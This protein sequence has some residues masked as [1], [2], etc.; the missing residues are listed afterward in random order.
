MIPISTREFPITILEISTELLAAL[1][2]KDMDL[3]SVGSVIAM[4]A[5]GRATFE[6][7]AFK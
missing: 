2:Y 3:N 7:A 4:P 1:W 5:D 6:P